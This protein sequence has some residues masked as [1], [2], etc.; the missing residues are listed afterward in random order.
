VNF[1]E[2]LTT[3]IKALNLGELTPVENHNGMYFKRDD[4]FQPFEDIPLSGGKVRQCLSLLSLKYDHIKE[5]CNNMVV[6]GTGVTSPQGII[7]TKCANYFDMNSIIYVG[8]TKPESL[9]RNTL[10]MNVLYQG[11]RLNYD[12]KQGYEVAL[13]ATIKRTHP[14]AYHIKF[15][16]NAQEVP[17][18]IIGS[19]SNQV[20]NIPDELDYLIVPCGSCIIFSGILLGI[21]KFNKKVKN[22]IGIQ[23]AGYDRTTTIQNL[24]KEDLP[25]KLLLSK[26]FPYSKKVKHRVDGINLDPLYEAKAYDYMVKYMLNDIDK[27][28]VLFWIVGD[29]NPVRDKIWKIELDTKTS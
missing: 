10:M 12:C 13:N 4:L 27:K 1:S 5:N 14:E 20:Q 7:V 24:I 19:T 6:T 25:Y 2:E 15:G 21:K 29:S 22:V 3:K 9:R 11:G 18:A 26:D 17:E 8:N 16:I 23:I 28:K